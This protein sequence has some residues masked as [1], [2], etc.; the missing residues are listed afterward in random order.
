MSERETGTRNLLRQYLDGV[1]SFQG[2]Q[3]LQIEILDTVDSGKHMNP[4]HQTPFENL[5]E[6][7]RDMAAQFAKQPTRIGTRFLGEPDVVGVMCMFGMDLC[8]HLLVAE[9]GF[10][11][12]TSG[13]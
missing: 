7:G 5:P 3:C 2:H 6:I 9:M 1:L 4:E 10:E 13:L 12:M 8:T 11:P